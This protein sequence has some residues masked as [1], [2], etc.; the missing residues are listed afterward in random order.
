MSKMHFRVLVFFIL[1]ALVL[2]GFPSSSM[3]Q[4]AEVWTNLGLY[5]GQIYDIAIDPTNPDKMFAGSYMGDGLFMTTDGG[6][7][8]QAVVA[9]EAEDMGGE[10]SFKNH[11]VYAV[12]IAPS[13]NDVIYAA[14]NY[15][16]EKS[17]DGG[18]TWIHIYNGTMQRD[19]TNCPAY[20]Q[21]RFCYA[22]AIDPDDPQTVY[23]GTGGRYTDYEPC[24]AI[25]KTEDGGENWTK[26]NGPADSCYPGSGN[27][28]FSVVDLSI[29]PNN[30]NVI[31]AVTNDSGRNPGFDG[32][33]YR[34]EIDPQG[35]DTWTEVFS[36]DGGGF[37]NVEVKPNDSNS[38]F[39]AHKL[40]I[41]RHYFEADEWKYERILDYEGPEPPPPGEVFAGTVRGLAFDPKSPDVLYA[42]WK[43]SLSE[44]DN[45]DTGAKIARGV[46]PYGDDNWEIYPVDTEFLAI[47]VRPSDDSSPSEIIF[48]GKIFEG[49]YKSQDHGQSWTPVNNGINALMINDVDVDPNDNSHILAGTSAGAFEKQ[50]A[51]DWTLTSDLDASVQSVAFDP[52]DTDGSTYFAGTRYKVAK[53]IDNGENWSLSNDITDQWVDDIA[54]RPGGNTIFIATGAVSGN[55]S[56]VY[57]SVNG[58]SD[59]TQV[60]SSDQFAFNSVVIDPSDSDH[61]FAGGGNFFG[62]RRLGNLYE[63]TVGGD[64]GTWQLTGLTNVIVNALLVDP[65]DSNIMYAGCGHSGGTQVPVYKSIDGGAN[66]TPS[67]EGIPEVGIYGRAV[68]G[69]SGSDVFV[70]ADNGRILHYD[71]STWTAMRSGATGIIFN[72]WGTSGTD[73]FVVGSGGTIHHYD[74]SDWIAMD[75]GTT[76]DLRGVW[77]TSGTDVF[78]IGNSGTLL[79]YNGSIWNA[80]DIS[81]LTTANLR[82][83]WGASGTDVFVS[84]YSGTILHYNGS[85]WIAMDS[86]TTEMVLG[87]WGTSGTDVFAV[88]GNGIT[89]HFNGTTWDHMTSGTTEEL[90]CVWGSSGTDVFAVGMNGTILHYDGSDWTSMDSGTTDYVWRVWGSSGTD[91]FAVDDGGGNILHY[92]GS[93]WASMWNREGI[94]WNSVTDLKFHPQNKNVI[95]AG[96]DQ[97]GVYVSPNQAG[98]WLNLGT[99]VYAVRAISTGSLYAA[100]QGGLMQCTGTGVMAGQVTD[101][102]DQS[103]IDGATVFNDLGVVTI[104]VNGEYMMISPSGICNVTVVADGHANTTVNY[105]TV[106]GGD[107][108][109]T[110]IQMQAGV[111]DYS[112][113]PQNGTTEASAGSYCF[114]AT[115]AYGSPMA[116]Q[117]EVLRQFR[118]SYLLPHVVGR[119]LV[120]LYYR[121]GKPIAMYIDSHPWLKYIVRGVL[122][123]IVG[124]A[125]LS[126][127]TSAMT[128]GFICLCISICVIWVIRRCIKIRSIN[129]KSKLKYATN[130]MMVLLF[131]VLI[132]SGGRLHAGTLFQQVGIASSPNTVGSGARAVGMGGA[133][134]AIADDATA[135]S[136]NPAGLIQ[137]EKPEVSIVGAYNNRREDFSSTV[138]PETNNTGEVDDCSINY[139]SA[140]YPF[141]FHKNMVVSINYQ[142]L[143]E[144]NRSFAHHLDYSSAGVNLQ[145]EK[146]FMQDGSLGALGIAASVEITPRLSFGATF[147][148]WTDQFVWKNGWNDSFTEHAVG[149]TAGVPVTIDTHITDD[150]SHF[151]GINANFG[152]LWDINQYLT[153][154]AVVKT[155][156]KASL[157]HTYSFDQTQTF[158]PPTST[159]VTS[160]QDLQESVELEMPLSY[161][162]GVAWRLS[163]AFTIDFDIYRTNWS[164][165]ILTDGQGNK[166]S[167]IDGRPE[168]SSDVKDTTQIRFGGEYLFI[169]KGKKMAIPVRAGIFYDP[170][171]SHG[172]F[173]DFYGITVGSGMAYKQFVFDAAYQLRWGK[174]VDT[175]NLIATSKA[176][177]IQH[178]ILAS[179]IY[180]F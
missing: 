104:S 103:S 180:H 92:D 6:D 40:G 28:D 26:M 53:T 50:G 131:A 172:G 88:G 177:I 91:V 158:G 143:F 167:P 62:T 14:H 77:G 174:D 32:T 31:W 41:F 64:A 128:K 10:D 5:G 44:W 56:G 33:L 136:W 145:Q 37:W 161:G 135:A 23:V 13:N 93:A 111:P 139:F 171:P 60:F 173:K 112:A 97:Q 113:I 127:S 89:L 156:F 61:I 178:L 19:C 7:S 169:K 25:Y 83:V 126:V 34:C 101:A 42:T 94:N 87:L 130:I 84:G 22:V 137:L 81:G 18:Q 52:T 148:I 141:L 164:K 72:F 75:S 49:V 129:K 35:T 39:T 38:I 82:S 138:R 149:S 114:I 118:D 95:Y 54:I 65:T 122:Y 76:E 57:R 63:S 47:A 168:G 124:L 132:F 36:M 134:I 165:Y 119:K 155:P 142:R 147:N 78:A 163:D 59:F 133:F 17:T 69:T 79:R 29:D 11:A 176:D 102:V 48:G 110:D 1:L 106:W 153:V 68:W 15:W 151:R 45:V 21:F 43:N 73:V 116:K 66:W 86:G 162:I 74:G 90:Q 16:V 152:M 109:S 123:P 51:G 3:S 159:T 144:F 12:K 117:V 154:G 20:D 125:W 9:A 55:V 179:V 105:I 2:C 175:G 99:P 120:A 80:I 71:G 30:H 58:G 121:T 157:V 85:D 98:K 67:F 96:T 140:A 146:N 27:F 100:T 4:G 24:G 70:G 160:Q 150:Y 166:F 115:A 108:A 107:V 46:P 170:E 8:W